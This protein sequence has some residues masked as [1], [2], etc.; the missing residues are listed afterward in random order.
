LTPTPF[1]ASGD[2]AVDAEGNIF[3]AN[4]GTNANDITGAEVYKVTPAGRVSLFASGFVGA[5]GNTFDSQG[6][7]YQT[8]TNDNRIYKISPQGVVSRFADSS[9]GLATP[10]GLTVNLHPKLHH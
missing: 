6:I 8:S 5:T 1:V 3:V 7:L 4:Y 9:Q 2:L 10:V